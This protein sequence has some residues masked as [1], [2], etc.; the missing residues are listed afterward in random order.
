MKTPA[1]LHRYLAHV[2]AVAHEIVVAVAVEE[3]SSIIVALGLAALGVGL[4]ILAAQIATAE[5]AAAGAIEA[6]VAGEG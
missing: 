4:L 1:I 5:P 6:V 3:R 2:L